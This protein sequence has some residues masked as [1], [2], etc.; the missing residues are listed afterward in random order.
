MDSWIAE[1]DRG[2][3]VVIFSGGG[4]WCEWCWWIGVLVG[5]KDMVWM[6]LWVW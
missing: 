5:K 6:E 4:I 1:V 3:V 2:E